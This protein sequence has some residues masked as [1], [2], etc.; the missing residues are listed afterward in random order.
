MTNYEWIQSLD[1]DKL[2]I[3]ICNIIE[4]KDCPGYNNC[5]IY[6]N[7]MQE[8]LRKEHEE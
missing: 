4:C 2:A 1:V 8:W 5:W 7:G 3:E 6:H